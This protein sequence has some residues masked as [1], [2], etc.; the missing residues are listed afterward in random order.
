M[1]HTNSKTR[2]STTGQVADAGTTTAGADAA[3]TTVTGEEV[4]VRAVSATAVLGSTKAVVGTAEAAEA[5]EGGEEEDITR[6][7]VAVEGTTRVVG[8]TCLEVVA[9][10]GREHR[11]NCL[12]HA[13]FYLDFQQACRDGD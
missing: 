10:K 9:G 6:G 12:Q 8:R 1:P 2:S 7:G 11:E 13:S 3:T 5:V 4:V